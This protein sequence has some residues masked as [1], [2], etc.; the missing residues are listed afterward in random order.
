LRTKRDAKDSE[1]V[2]SLLHLERVEREESD[3]EAR[4]C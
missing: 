3:G 1:F 2:L 4:R